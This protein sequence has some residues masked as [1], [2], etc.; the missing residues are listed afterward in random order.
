MFK[1]FTDG[2]ARGN[3]GPAGAGA[4]IIDSNNNVKD[5]LKS[6]L[7]NKTNNEA[8]Y[9]ALLLGLTLAVKNN[10]KD[11]ECNMDSELL[12]KQLNGEYKVKNENL[13]KLYLKV[14][15]IE[16]RFTSISYKHIPRKENASADALVNQ[17]LDEST[18]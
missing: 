9:M 1:L 16:K 15:D 7:G 12:V 18:S 8:E 17:I 10:I 13:K 14:K 4:L 3:P 11:L 2:G 6:Y 5:Q